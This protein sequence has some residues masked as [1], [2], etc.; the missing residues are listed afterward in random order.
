MSKNI[1]VTDLPTSQ[2][3]KELVGEQESYLVHKAM[4]PDPE[5]EDYFLS[6][7][8]SK[9]FYGRECTIFQ[10]FTLSELATVLKKIGEVKGWGPKISGRDSRDRVE[11][12]K[13]ESRQMIIDEYLKVCELVANDGDANGYLEELLK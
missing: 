8:H 1:W 5:D 9:V 6:D 3:I 2:R 12:K 4:T 7:D 10:A 13:E 11:L